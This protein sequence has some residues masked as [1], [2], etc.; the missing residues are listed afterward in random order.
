[1][2]VSKC[3]VLT[4]FYQSVCPPSGTLTRLEIDHCN[5]MT[6]GVGRDLVR[7]NQLRLLSMAGQFGQ[8]RSDS[9]QLVTGSPLG[10]QTLAMILVQLPR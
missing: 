3:G 2:P 4:Y 8:S 5:M 10:L 6:D 9:Y 7:L 1:M